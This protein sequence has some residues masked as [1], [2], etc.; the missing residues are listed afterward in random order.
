MDRRISEEQE[1]QKNYFI[2]TKELKY[3]L[4]Q[5]DDQIC[6]FEDQNRKNTSAS[7]QLQRAK[8]YEEHR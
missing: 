2:L 5:A 3:E 6:Y 1:K 7:C 8:D 4:K